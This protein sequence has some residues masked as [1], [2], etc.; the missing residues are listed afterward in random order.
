M[1][2]SRPPR[3]TKGPWDQQGGW[4]HH[5]PRT[6]LVI[7]QNHH[8]PYIVRNTGDFFYCGASSDGNKGDGTGTSFL[9]LPATLIR[10]SSVTIMQFASN[11]AAVVQAAAGVVRVNRP[12][13]GPLVLQHMQGADRHRALGACFDGATAPLVGSSRAPADGAA[14]VDRLIPRVV[15]ARAR[16]F[17]AYL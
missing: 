12:L 11:I 5:L 8:A 3:R 6:N 9:L 1:L 10:T 7:E 16:G 15:K 14:Q 2:R 17:V 13:A 4:P